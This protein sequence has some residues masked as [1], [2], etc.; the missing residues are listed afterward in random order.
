[1]MSWIVGIPTWIVDW[2]ASLLVVISLIFLFRKNIWYWHFSNASV[3]PYFLLFLSTQQYML[4]GLQV[5][6]L[7]FGL[8]GLYLWWLEHRRDDRQQPFNERFWYNLGWML[9]LAI[10]AFTVVITQFQD[11]WTWLQFIITSLSLVAN[12]ATTRKW[13]WSWYLWIFVNLLQGILFN[14]LALWAQ[15]GLQVVLAGMSVKGLFEWQ[16]DDRNR[17]SKF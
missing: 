17:E 6:Y 12:W 5:S 1:M 2:S 11:G 16:Q 3:L 14:H 10:F 8:H 9:T 7:I 13:N 15:V 4:A